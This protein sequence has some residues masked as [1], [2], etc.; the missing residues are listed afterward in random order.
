MQWGNLDAE[1]AVNSRGFVTIGGNFHGVVINLLDASDVRN[2]FG[3]HGFVLRTPFADE[4]FLG[5]FEYIHFIGR[6]VGEG[7][8]DII[9][10]GSHNLSIVVIE[11]GEG[12]N[13]VV[14]GFSASALESYRICTISDFDGFCAFS[15][16]GGAEEASETPHAHGKGNFC[17]IGHVIPNSTVEVLGGEIIV[18]IVGSNIVIDTLNFSFDT[19]LEASPD[20]ILLFLSP[21]IGVGVDMVLTGSIDI[22]KHLEVF[23]IDLSGGLSLVILQTHDRV[24][25][26]GGGTNIRRIQEGVIGEDHIVGGHR[27]A[28]G[29]LHTNAQTG[30]VFGG[31]A[32]FVIINI[33]VSSALIEVIH[34][35]VA[36]GFTVNRIED[37]SADAVGGHEANLGHG[38]NVHVVASVAKEGAEL[39]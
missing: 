10:V 29:E 18:A 5:N 7:G 13:Q 26:E 8:N 25:R 33:D 14:N 17:A 27:L 36:V 34:A 31:V 1:N 39:L 28:I 35:V 11:G 16:F 9:L 20:V 38:S 30:G 15:N 3:A 12:L 21:C 23:V 6:F 32:G 24:R 37:D 2:T 4:G 22:S 19:G